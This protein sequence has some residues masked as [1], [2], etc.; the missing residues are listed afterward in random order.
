M[1]YSAR[2]DKAVAQEWN[3]KSSSFDDDAKGKGA[4][5]GVSINE[6]KIWLGV[7]GSS[8][9]EDKRLGLLQLCSSWVP[10]DMP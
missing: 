7:S 1:D 10:T 8:F 6:R 9:A 3:L 2:K 5:F 4:C